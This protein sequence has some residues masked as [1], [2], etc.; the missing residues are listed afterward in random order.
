MWCFSFCCNSQSNQDTND[1]QSLKNSS[2]T[3]IPKYSLNN[4]ILFG[5]VVSV[6]DGDTFTINLYQPIFKQMFQYTARCIGLDCPEMKPSIHLANRDHLIQQAHRSRNLMTE[7]LTGLPLFSNE[8][9]LSLTLRKQDIEQLIESIPN[10]NVRILPFHCHTWDKYG[11]LLVSI[12]FDPSC[13]YWPSTH[14]SNLPKTVSEG[15]IQLHLGKEY[16]GG[17]KKEW[18]IKDF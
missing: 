1:L 4:Q 7:W 11:R 2:L 10:E 14:S 16:D 9:P 15:M 12:A 18:S 5:K 6:Y 13:M 8:T 17:S 3:S